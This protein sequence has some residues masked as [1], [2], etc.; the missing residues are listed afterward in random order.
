MATSLSSPRILPTHLEQFAPTTGNNGQTVRLLG[1]ITAIHGTQASLTSGDGDTVTLNMQRDSHLSPQSIYEV[2]GKVINLDNGQGLGM[3]VL[4]T[5]EW[6]KSQDG[7]SVDL[8]IYE[9]VVDATHKHK[10]LFYGED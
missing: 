4:S 2:V 7:K 6:P 9:A 3:R 5:T 1:T 10:E 8:K